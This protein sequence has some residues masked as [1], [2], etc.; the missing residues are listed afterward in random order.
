MW[1]IIGILLGLAV[2]GI[3]W[4]MRSKNASFTWYE[5]IIGLVGLA[6][7]LFGIQNLVGGIAE[8]ESMAG[9]LILMFFGI[10]AIIL[11][12]VVWRLATNRMKSA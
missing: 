6:L 8:T 2:L 12:A 1:F 4:L 11:L 3:V 5:W 7:L 10:P 9:W